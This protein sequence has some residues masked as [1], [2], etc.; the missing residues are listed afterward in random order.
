MLLDINDLLGKPYKVHGRDP[1]GYDCYGLV[2]EVERRLGRNLPDLYKIFEKKSDVR[3]VTLSTE[4]T[5]L[6]K[7]DTPSFGDIIVFRKKGRA[8]HVAVYLKDRDFIHCDCNGVEILNLDYYD[9]EGEFYT[10]L[11]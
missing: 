7:T 5:G 8:D 6:I 10:W 4:A 3:N 11:Q 9:K 2:I 1:D